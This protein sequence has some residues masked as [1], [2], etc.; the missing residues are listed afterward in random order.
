MGTYYRPDKG[1]I[2]DSDFSPEKSKDSQNL[3][4]RAKKLIEVLIVSKKIAIE[5]LK[6]IYS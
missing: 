5:D 3:G 2:S 6:L 1:M 4:L